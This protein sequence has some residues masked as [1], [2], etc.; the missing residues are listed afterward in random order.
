MRIEEGES[1]RGG[2]QVRAIPTYPESRFPKREKGDNRHCEALRAAA[3]S[4]FTLRHLDTQTLRHYF[5]GGKEDGS[6]LKKAESPS[7]VS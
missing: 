5:L 7:D 6:Y 2:P 4:F 3:I 1:L